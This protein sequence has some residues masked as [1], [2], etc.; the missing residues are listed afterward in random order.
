MLPR[1]AQKAIQS[2]SASPAYILFEEALEERLDVIRSAFCRLDMGYA[3]AYSIKTNSLPVI[4]RKLASYGLWADV[5]S[6]LEIECAR[7]AGFSQIIFNGI[8]KTKEE[9]ERAIELDAIVVLDGSGQINDLFSIA[10]RVGG[11]VHCGLRI[12][13]YPIID[14]HGARFGLF[15][16][17]KDIGCIA[18]KLLTKNNISLDCLHMHLGTNV[19]DLEL[20]QRAFDRLL[21]LRNVIERET[22][23]EI[24]YIDI[25]G[26]FPANIDRNQLEL[27]FGQFSCR[28]D[29]IENG[30]SIIVE[31][32]RSLVQDA[33]ILLASVVDVRSLPNSTNKAVILDVGTNSFLGENYGVS[34]DVKIFGDGA[35]SDNEQRYTI[36]GPLCNTE[37]LIL[38]DYVSGEIK[39]GDRCVVI[40]VGAYDFSTSYQFSRAMPQVFYVTAD[41]SI[42]ALNTLGDCK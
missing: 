16:S 11:K 33:G 37:D 34:H 5:T 13:A 10:E 41:G 8:Y 38:N 31:P 9:L 40:G 21:R 29:R 36:Y 18:K 3:I 4:S 26:G 19:C 22:G 15:G 6:S 2:I 12:T 20:Y 23:C 7:K 24:P 32:G 27:M 39:V 14:D 17:D 42:K 1:Y 28:D 30:V 25:G 35:L